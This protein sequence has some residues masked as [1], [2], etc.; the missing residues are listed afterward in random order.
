MPITRA[1]DINVYWEEHGPQDASPVFFIGGSGGDLRK[2]PNIMDGPLAKSARVLAYDQRGLGQTDKPDA[3][4]SMA[5]YADDAAALMDACG[6]SKAHVIGVSFGGMVAQHLAQRHPDKIDKLVMCC[7][8]PG[9]DGGSSYPLHTVAAMGEEERIRFMAPIS[10]TRSDETW[11]AE[12][13]DL[14]ASLIKM[15]VEAEAPYADE[16]RRSEGALWQLEARKDHDAWEGLA[17]LPHPTLICGGKYD[18]IATPDTQQRMVDRIPNA[19]LKMYEGGHLFLLQDRA[20]WA[21][22][23]AFLDLD[24]DK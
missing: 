11:Q 9:G 1:G 3:P 2:K 8:S 20:A 6:W 21:D 13:A 7:T 24:T 12:N 22:I 4:Y 15:Q 17:T 14:F 19:T 10:D 23:M 5:Q 16:H 18:G